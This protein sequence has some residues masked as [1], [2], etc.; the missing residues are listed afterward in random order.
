MTVPPVS[1]S[2]SETGSSSIYSS[3][4]QAPYSPSSSGLS[5]NPVS[6]PEPEENPRKPK[7]PRES[8]SGSGSKHPVFRGVRMR[9]WG[10][11]VSEI[12]EPRKKNRIWLGTFSTPEMAARA[13]DVAALSIKGKSA[14]LNFPKLAGSL[15]RPA[16][17]SP[18]DVQDAAAKAASMDF[19]IVPSDPTK[20]CDDENN[21]NSNDSTASNNNGSSSSLVTQ[22][23]S[24][25]SSSSTVEVTSSPSD[26]AT[27]EELSEIVE[28]PSLETS[29]E[30]FPEFVLSGDLWPYNI[31]Q[32]WY[33]EDYGAEGTG[34]FSD[35]YLSIIPES[36]VITT[37]GAFETLLWEH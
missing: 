17:N 21:S 34:Y 3:S 22:S 4:P 26:V 6:K 1:N 32:S 30:E 14:I 12:R 11:W 7:R 13:H 20:V 10:K 24:S 8:G 25:P 36:N 2:N 27:P 9:T 15:P 19:N 23:S 16:S 37:T 33:C 5:P 28:L 18:R 29:F 31:N 35:Q